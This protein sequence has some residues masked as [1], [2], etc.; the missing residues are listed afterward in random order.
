VWGELYEESVL[1]DVGG[2]AFEL[3][4]LEACPAKEGGVG[5]G[6]FAEVLCEVFVWVCRAGG[7]VFSP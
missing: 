1:A 7:E 5:G 4:G 6:E 2:Y 3:E